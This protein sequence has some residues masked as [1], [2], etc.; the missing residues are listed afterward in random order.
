MS[1]TYGT[2]WGRMEQSHKNK[3]D[4]CEGRKKGMKGEMSGGSAGSSVSEIYGTKRGRIE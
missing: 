1:E 3:C 2:K 4:K